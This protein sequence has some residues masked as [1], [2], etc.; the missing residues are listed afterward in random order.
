MPERTL[1]AQLGDSHKSRAVIAVIIRI[2]AFGNR[3]KTLFFGNLRDLF[4]ELAFTQIAAV[5][6]IMAESFDLQLFRINDQVTDILVTAE[7]RRLR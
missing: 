3:G 2:R 4:K 7:S 6:W 1:D 5:F